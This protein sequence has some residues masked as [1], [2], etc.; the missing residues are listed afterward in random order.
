MKLIKCYVSSFGKLK[1]F[2]Y[3][4]SSG[5]NTIKEDNGFGKSTLAT[6]I[7]AVFY[8]LNDSKRNVADNERTKFR[9]WNS[10]G[11]FGGYIEFEWGGQNFKIERFFGNKESEDT[12][13][14]YDL[15]TGRVHDNPEDI[16][17]R[18]FEIDEEG[19]LSTT[20]FSQ[21]DFQIK[22][23]TSLTAKFNSVCEIQ[24]SETFDKALS[25][26][27][28]KA[29][30]YKSR[31][32]KGLISDNQQQIFKINDKIEEANKAVL[33]A[34]S[35]KIQ[36]D[37]L[38]RETIELK[39]KLVK[40][41]EAEKIASKAEVDSIKKG[42]YER[43][44]A[45]A[46]RLNEEKVQAEKFLNGH[47]TS[48]SEVDAYI[49]CARELENIVI[50]ER[51]LKEDV[52]QLEQP[53]VKEKKNSKTPL[54]IGASSAVSIVLAVIFAFALGLV[55]I[56]T[57]VFGALGVCAGVCALVLGLSS[58]KNVQEIDTR[59]Q[60][61]VQNKKQELLEFGKIKAEY[62]Y[63]IDA[64]ISRFNVSQKED[65]LGALE[66]IKK[67]CLE[68]SATVKAIAGVVSEMKSFGEDKSFLQTAKTSVN[69][70]SVH[71]EKAKVQEEYDFK[72]RELAK[73][74][75][76][77]RYY[78]ELSAV[79][80]ELEEQKIRLAEKQAQYKED[81]EL[82][83]LTA[84]FL[85]KADENLKVKYRAPLQE[86]LNKYLR[87]IVGEKVDA[88]IDID[89]TVTIEE[90]GAEKVTDYYSKGYQNLFEICKRF[91]LTDVLFKG[92]KPFIILDDPFYNLD[93]DK[94]RSALELIGKLSSE[95]QIVYFVCH[96]SRKPNVQA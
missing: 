87:L 48:P 16:G 24:D 27:E 8:G 39:E 83:N 70:D 72:M 25:K 21:K 31:G 92:E 23:N 96:E 7:K 76:S 75:A 29:K 78:D 94:L 51:G 62:L 6:F 43:L 4:F 55:S 64:Y 11:V 54:V 32:D 88:K 71:V 38:E 58:G 19:F 81:Y 45:E 49:T 46:E 90:N 13:K 95:Y 80:P 66:E 74:Q 50:R 91:A 63:K 15:K 41:T 69:L 28:E 52:A 61:I 85:K 35:L 53:V 86:S 93:D 60:E 36:S 65:M 12:V 79:L 26:V 1:D 47:I 56:P 30:T 10:V 17:R 33:T 20:Y 18:I 3:E 34:T 73:V 5:L 2:T 68:Y 44:L 59:Y 42:Q 37:A 9:P 67:V 89:L 84:D 82:L 14:L 22:S 77:V 57:I 40:A